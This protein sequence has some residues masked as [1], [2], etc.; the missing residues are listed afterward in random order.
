MKVSKQIVC[1]S[2]LLSNLCCF[3]YQQ[4]FY[5]S[6]HSSDEFSFISDIVLW[7]C[8]VL[9]GKNTRYRWM[10]DGKPNNQFLKFSYQSLIKLWLSLYPRNT[11]TLNKNACHVKWTFNCILGACLVQIKC[12]YMLFLSSLVVTVDKIMHSN[13]KRPSL[14]LLVI[15]FKLVDIVLMIVI[16]FVRWMYW[17]VMKCNET[18]SPGCGGRHPCFLSSP[19]IHWHPSPL[20]VTDHKMWA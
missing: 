16:C 8:N 11:F 7:V 18:L 19:T 15:G 6:P 3:A 4:H 9:S 13:F 20:C 10:L 14:T 1:S 5:F 2:Q 17:N 12:V